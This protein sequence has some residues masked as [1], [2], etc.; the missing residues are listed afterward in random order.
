MET[1]AI[2]IHEKYLSQLKP[3][4]FLDPPDE[5]SFSAS[6]FTYCL[7]SNGDIGLRIM[8]I[9]DKTKNFAF[10]LQFRIN[11]FTGVETAMDKYVI[12]AVAFRPLIL[13]NSDPEGL[14]F[15]RFMNSVFNT[16]HPTAKMSDNAFFNM[17]CLDE[18]R[19]PKFESLL[20]KKLHFKLFPEDQSKYCEFYLNVDF[21]NKI[22]ELVEK[23]S[24]Y[25]DAIYSVFFQ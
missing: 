18:E 8:P 16:S 15:S 7:I 12:D 17:I 21:P 13:K 24:E 19:Y 14:N 4:A 22:I 6:I 3:L 1:P 2:L 20:N 25:R 5:F 9:I 10:D 11:D 23:D